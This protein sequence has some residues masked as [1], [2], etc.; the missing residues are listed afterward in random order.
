MKD[1]RLQEILRKVRRLDLMAR[2]RSRERVAGQYHSRFKGQG[3]D[4]ADH[5]AYLPGDDV[6]AIDWNVTARMPE[7]YIRTFEEE[8]EMT[9]Y[10]LV[11]ISPSTGYGS[12]DSSKRELAAEAA[13]TIAFSAQNNHDKTGL[14]LYGHDV[15]YMLPAAKGRPH[16]LRLLRE[17]LYRRSG[18]GVTRPA[19]AL[20]ALQ[21]AVRR[22][23]LAFLIGDMIGEDFSD[24]LKPA[25]RRHEII[26]L[27]IED[28]A[29]A[30]PP[31]VGWACL[32]DP[33]TGQSAV[34]NTSDTV[35]RQRLAQS[36][37]RWAAEIDST[38]GRLG[39]ASATLRTDADPARALQ[40][41]LQRRSRH[42]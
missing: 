9:V 3:I 38:F 27:R 12:I 1:D 4:F 16:V 24:T 36:H 14:I 28:P 37:L 33:E 19:T 17:I 40:A 35:L 20:K 15:E 30:K 29:E 5:R 39:C 21:T 18:P 6:R 11:D 7:P 23:A 13:A 31:D 25:A 32:E 41:L 22:H 42:A 34:V 26:G 10:L 8:R 2:T